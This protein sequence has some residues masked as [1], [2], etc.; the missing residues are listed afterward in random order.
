[1]TKIFFLQI[2]AETNHETIGDF[3]S[4]PNQAPTREAKLRKWGRE[5]WHLYGEKEPS[6]VKGCVI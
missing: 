1:M 6:S 3:L 5:Y 2:P 4:I